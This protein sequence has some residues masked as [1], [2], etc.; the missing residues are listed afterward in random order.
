VLQTDLSSNLDTKNWG[1][2]LV[3]NNKVIAR[4]ASPN[5]KA[6]RWA[7]LT[8]AQ[9]RQ[10][11]E[12]L[13]R[14]NNTK[15]GLP[16]ARPGKACRPSIL[17]PGRKV[18]RSCGKRKTGLRRDR[19]AATGANW[20]RRA[21]ANSTAALKCRPGPNRK[22]RLYPFGKRTLR[23]RF[24]PGPIPR[25]FSP[26]IRSL[27]TRLFCRLAGR[28]PCSPYLAVL[29]RLHFCFLPSAFCS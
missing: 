11:S 22:P 8:R 18:P 15:A 29:V 14:Q 7:L 24:E 9:G 5:E 28:R 4:S 13:K 12:L 19:A 27:A 17:S 26:T 1:R 3:P 20:W 16:Q 23:C 6:P 2:R 21:L 25:L 10:E